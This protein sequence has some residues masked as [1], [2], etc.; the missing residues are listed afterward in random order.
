MAKV[1]AGD[2]RWSAMGG[3]AVTSCLVTWAL[4]GNPSFFKNND[5]ARWVVAGI[6]L[7]TTG[8]G[9]LLSKS[10]AGYAASAAAAVAI[11]GAALMPDAVPTDTLANA[12]G[13][14]GTMGLSV[15]AAIEASERFNG[16]RR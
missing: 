12:V 1:K 5:I 3:A 11:S 4:I 16:R 6:G 9:A 15:I 8:V 13:N 2:W 7:G 10:R 14:S